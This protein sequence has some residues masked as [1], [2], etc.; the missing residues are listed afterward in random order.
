[1][2]ITELIDELQLLKAQYGDIQVTVKEQQSFRLALKVED[3]LDPRT[4]QSVG[5]IIVAQ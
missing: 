1:M 3:E 2:Y 5:K 4:L